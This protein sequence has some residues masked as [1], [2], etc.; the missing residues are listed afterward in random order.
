[1]Q[2]TPPLNLA[3]EWWR[4]RLG[5]VIAGDDE[6][7]TRVLLSR[8]PVS[9]CSRA[10]LWRAWSVER[11]WRLNDGPQIVVKAAGN[12]KSLSGTRAC[13]RYVGRS[14]A[15]DTTPVAVFDEFGCMV[16]PLAAL[17]DW[18]LLE[19]HE[20]LSRQARDDADKGVGWAERRRLHYVQSH[21][22]IVSIP[23]SVLKAVPNG[24]EMFDRAALAAIDEAFTAKGFRVL[25]GR[26]DDTPEHPHLHMVVKAVSHFGE[27]LRF[28]R[29]GQMFDHL[30]QM[31]ADN[32]CRA[33]LK[34]Q[35]VRREDVSESRTAI[36]AGQQE[37]RPRSTRFDGDLATR[38]PYWV[39]AFG[40][41]VLNVGQGPA[42]KAS[43]W[44]RLRRKKKP[45]TINVPKVYEDGV[46]TMAQHYR[47][48]VQALHRWLVLARG[49]QGKP[50]RALALW[51]L[52]HRPEVFGP[53]ING[54][55]EQSTE[56]LVAVLR[57]LPLPP[58]L[59]RRGHQSNDNLAHWVENRRK[60]RIRHDRQNL[61]G[62]LWRLATRVVSGEHPNPWL[63]REIVIRA[64]SALVVAVQWEIPVYI[65]P[66]AEAAVRKPAAESPADKPEATGGGMGLQVQP[67]IPPLVPQNH[68]H[69]APSA[70]QRSWGK[71]RSL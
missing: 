4:K 44:S 48:P 59:M 1:M 19:D 14:R 6:A 33:G 16:D 70:R 66:S 18:D 23:A 2:D 62:S 11:H 43:W 5:R 31:F 17:R 21:H 60:R 26:H 65:E 56:K 10:V 24:A 42:E 63:A 51:Y 47:D 3:E 64:C 54:P 15:S 9:G 57:R 53:Q 20:N 7:V 40:A 13:L 41:D 35:A 25:W 30:R 39:A 38:A 61:I 49:E 69:V 71:S 27:R 55:R 29:D 68:R 34:V 46:G 36:M 28:D 32:F 67:V 45:K 50:E 52:R 22:L 37:L 58:P 8:K 12:R